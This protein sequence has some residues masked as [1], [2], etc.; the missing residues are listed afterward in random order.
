MSPT[1]ETGTSSTPPRANAP[2]HG[3]IKIES[4]PN[5]RGAS[6]VSE[7]IGVLGAKVKK[8]RPWI[9]RDIEQVK[10]CEADAMLQALLQRASSTPETKQPELL[11]KCLKAASTALIKSSEV[12]LALNEYVHPGAENKFHSPFIRATDIALACLEEIKVDGMRAPV[13]A[14]DMIYDETRKK[15]RKVQMDTNATAK[16]KNL[17]WKDILACIEF[18]RKTPGRTKGINPQPPSYTL[19]GYVPTKPEYLQVDDLRAEDP[20]P[21]PSQAP[22]AQPASDTALL[23][24]G[25]SAAKPSKRSSSPKPDTDADL[26]VT[27]QTGLYAAEM[28][29]SNLGVNHL[30]NIIAIDDIIWIWYYDR[31]GIVQ[32]SGI[33]FV[34]DLPRFMV[35]LYALQRL[36]LHDWGRN[37]D[38]LPVQ[39]EGKQWHEF[40]IKDVELGEGN[41]LLHTSQDERVT[42]YGLQLRAA[43]TG[44]QCGPCHQRSACEEI[45]QSP[46]WD[47][48]QD[49]LGERRVALASRKFWTRSYSRAAVHHKFANPTSAIREALVVPDPT[50]GGRVLYILVFRKLEPITELHGKTLFDVWYQCIHLCGSSLWIVSMCLTRTPSIDVNNYYDRQKGQTSRVTNSEESESDVDDFL[51]SFKNTE[52][53]AELSTLLREPSQ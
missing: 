34:Q 16:P 14:V 15:K 52:S 22:A 40:K 42:H 20:T 51:Q 4:T 3:A 9:Q 50:T 1:G 49:L 35:L 29:A 24:S 43:R 12:E 2:A 45:R 13:P 18:K 39:V 7:N 44:H 38:F 19:T 21:G 33:N 37:K 36:D 11:Q 17:P 48:S 26:D 46:G 53:W 30:L 32:C 31:Q 8:V 6:A 47:G 10:Q 41:L 25:L 27:V 5:S 23:S 28:F